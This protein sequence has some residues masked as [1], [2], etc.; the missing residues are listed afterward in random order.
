MIPAA[1]TPSAIC[2]CARAPLRQFHGQ[3]RTGPYKPEKPQAETR[4]ARFPQPGNNPASTTG[5]DSPH[6]RHAQALNQDSKPVHLPSTPDAPSTYFSQARA[7]GQRRG[8]SGTRSTRRKHVRSLPVSK[9]TTHDAKSRSARLVARIWGFCARCTFYLLSCRGTESIS[10]FARWSCCRCASLPLAAA[11]VCL[12]TDMTRAS[13]QPGSSA[14]ALFLGRSAGLIGQIRRCRVCRGRA[15][16][17]DRLAEVTGG[18]VGADTSSHRLDFAYHAKYLSW[19][20]K[21]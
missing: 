17:P 8:P 10:P 20:A 6:A 21:R 14:H 13:G 2:T 15:S 7:T 4:P 18:E 16:W 3:P 5:P 11:A 1:A 9:R 12:A 19:Y